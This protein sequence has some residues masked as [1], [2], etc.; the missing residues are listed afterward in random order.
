MK[1]L[2][3]S[4][5]TVALIAQLVF[6]VP[7]SYAYSAPVESSAKETPQSDRMKTSMERLENELVAKYGEGQ[8]ARLRRGMTQVANFWR[9]RMAM[10]RSLKSL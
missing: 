7:V 6:V 3:P 10:R 8:R 4:I 5:V 2:N 1:S 9:T